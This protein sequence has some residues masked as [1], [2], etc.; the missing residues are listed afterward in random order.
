MERQ[1]LRFLRHC[2][3]YGDLL[4][5][6]MLSPK[7]KHQADPRSKDAPCVCVFESAWLENRV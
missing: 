6:E 1:R 5:A 7:V 3:T 2:R 4:E